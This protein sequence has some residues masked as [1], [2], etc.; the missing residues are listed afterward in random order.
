MTPLGLSALCLRLVNSPRPH[1]PLTVRAPPPPLQE[2]NYHTL[3]V[4]LL[5]KFNDKE[6]YRLMVKT[7]M[8]YVKVRFV[9]QAG[10]HT[11]VGER[12]H[13]ACTPAPPH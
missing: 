6:L 5:D 11:S 8:Y 2:A 3:Y 1:P 10:G 4:S 9:R 7:T 13:H 12:T